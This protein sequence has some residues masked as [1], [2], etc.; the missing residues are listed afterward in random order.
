MN[1]DRKTPEEMPDSPFTTPQP[2]TTNDPAG[3]AKGQ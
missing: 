1:D 2:M 3:I